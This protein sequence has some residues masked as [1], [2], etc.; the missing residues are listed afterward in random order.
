[1]DRTKWCWLMNMRGY[2]DP[3]EVVNRMLC[4]CGHNG[5]LHASNTQNCC[6]CECEDVD[7]FEIGVYVERELEK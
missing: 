3:R 1:M 7:S 5:G 6:K 2:R 4:D